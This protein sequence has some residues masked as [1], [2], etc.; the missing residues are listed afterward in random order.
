VF[1]WA[2]QKLGQALYRTGA[3]DASVAALRTAVEQQPDFPEAYLDLGR[4][5]YDM[6]A[7][8]EVVDAYEQAIRLGRGRFPEAHWG[9]GRALRDL[10]DLD[11][12]VDAFRTAISE[13][14]QLA[15]AR[16]AIAQRPT[17]ALA[18]HDLGVALYDRGSLR[19]ASDALRD[20]IRHADGPFPAAHLN[21]GTVLFD[22]GSIDEAGVRTCARRPQRRVPGRPL[23][24]R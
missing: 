12:A 6:G 4:S 18:L 1:P 8:A 3:L 22:L 9:L 13:A 21:R 14:P 23:Q 15:E 20:A 10:G 5:L 11:G 16:S 19:E 2:H 24:P 7:L 17:Y